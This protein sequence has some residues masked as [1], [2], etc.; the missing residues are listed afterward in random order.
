MENK[1]RHLRERIIR[2]EIVLE[3]IIDKYGDRTCPGGEICQPEDQT[4]KDIGRAIEIM[5]VGYYRPRKT[6]VEK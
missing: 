3:K 5:G 1:I 4:N 6:E 2:L